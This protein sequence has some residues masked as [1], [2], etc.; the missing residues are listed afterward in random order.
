MHRRGG[1]FPG[2]RAGE[3]TTVIKD[4]PDAQVKG[5]GSTHAGMV[6]LIRG[7]AHRQFGDH[8]GVV[9]DFG[10]W[11]NAGGADVADAAA[12]GI[13]AIALFTPGKG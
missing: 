3:K 5:G 12:L 8:L 10:G 13:L 11:A 9:G 7:V 2:R 4:I 1:R 6:I